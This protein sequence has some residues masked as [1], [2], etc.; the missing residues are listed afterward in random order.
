MFFS[1]LLILNFGPQHP[2][3]HGV[4]RLILQLNGELIVNCDSQIVFLH[5]STEILCEFKEFYKCTLYFDRLDYTSILTQTHAFCLGIE[6]F[7]FYSFVSWYCKSVRVIFAELARILN[8]L[9]AIST[10]SL[11]IGNMIPLFWAFEEREH[12]LFLFEYV[13]GARMHTG[14]FRPFYLNLVQFNYIFFLNLFFFCNLCNRTI[15]ELFLLLNNNKF[16][17]KRLINVGIFS[18]DVLFNFSASGPIGRSGAL[19]NDLR[20]SLELSYENYLFLNFY[21]YFGIN[22]D[23]FDRFLIRIYELFE[24]LLIIYQLSFNFIKLYNTIFKFKFIFNNLY[25][26]LKKY[27]FL[28]NTINF[29]DSYVESGKGFFGVSIYKINTKLFKCRIRSPAFF[30]LNLLQAQ[31][32]NCWLADLITIIGSQDLVFGEIDR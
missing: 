6:K 8:H 15:T 20:K 25:F 32:K 23:C 16:W 29:N 17:K 19:I 7:Y 2:A 18:S 24:S 4:L 3:A 27:Y 14:F 31:L 28:L 13:S 26:L 10:H 5:R 11:D 12:I 22:G 30:H 1:Q 21:C 9:L